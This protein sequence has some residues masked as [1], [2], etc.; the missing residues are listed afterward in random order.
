MQ[1]LSKR[2]S[3]LLEQFPGSVTIRYSKWCYAVPFA[4]FVIAAASIVSLVWQ[5]WPRVLTNGPALGW[6]LVL[7]LLLGVP[8]SALVLSLIKGLPRILL[9]ADGIA[10]EALVGSWRRPWA[11]VA[12][13]TPRVV[14]LGFWDLSQPRGLWDRLNRVGSRG[15]RFLFNMFELRTAE[16]G[17]LLAAWR[18]R[19]LSER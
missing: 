13:F 15:R 7:V 17:Q 2:A 16:L 18:E 6:L 5:T 9:T 4:L 19:A 3:A 11:D 14:Y 12:Q 10:C 1:P 8:A